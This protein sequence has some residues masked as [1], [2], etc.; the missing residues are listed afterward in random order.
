M[1]M[2]G[3]EFSP[4]VISGGST[5]TE[6]VNVCKECGESKLFKNREE[7]LLVLGAKYEQAKENL[8]N[9]KKLK[10]WRKRIYPT[11]FI[12]LVIPWVLEPLGLMSG[13]I[14]Y[15][16]FSGSFLVTVIAVLVVEFFV[17]RET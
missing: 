15:N 3:E 16:W 1:T 11:L 6:I 4:T 8:E 7:C 10:V 17:V 14:A 9:A 2:N 12:L 13:N 5:S